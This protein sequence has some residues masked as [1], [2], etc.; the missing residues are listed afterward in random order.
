VEV[1]VNKHIS[2]SHQ[3]NA[4]HDALTLGEVATTSY[5]AGAVVLSTCWCTWEEAG[6][7]DAMYCS[8]DAPSSLLTGEDIEASGAS[9]G[10]EWLLVL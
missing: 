6:V 9:K 3:K 1:A 10:G 5:N 2:T 8:M 7:G 4:R